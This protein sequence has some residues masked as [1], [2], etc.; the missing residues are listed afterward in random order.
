MMQKET[1]V[2]FFCGIVNGIV[3]IVGMQVAAM[4][5]SFK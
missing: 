3:G 5:Y 2:I 1:S 4:W